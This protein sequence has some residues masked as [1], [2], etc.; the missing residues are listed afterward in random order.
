LPLAAEAQQLDDFTWERVLALRHRELLRFARTEAFD[1]MALDAGHALERGER[2]EERMTRLELRAPVRRDDEHAQLRDLARE[3]LEQPQRRL[4]GGVE[5]V[6]HEHE[7]IGLGGRSQPADDGVMERV[8]RVGVAARRARL[9]ERRHEVRDVAAMRADPR[10]ELG[11]PTAARHRFE[12][13]DP[14][15]MRRGGC[16]RAARG[17][18]Y[19]LRSAGARAERELV[20]GPRLADAR[21]AAEQHDAPDAA[22]RRLEG[23]EEAAQERLASDE[24]GRA[25]VRAGLVARHDLDRR[26]EAKAAAANRDD[27]AGLPAVVAEGPPQVAEGDAKAASLTQTPARLRPGPRPST[28]RDRAVAEAGA[29]ARSA[30]ARAQPAR[31]RAANSPVRGSSSNVPERPMP[32][33]NTTSPRAASIGLQTNTGLRCL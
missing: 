14:D 1:A 10:V 15:V 2:R 8:A 19:G 22:A 16:G 6:D 32:K 5:I 27:E 28:P 3:R 20:G 33:R 29:A 25:A 24:A 23:R 4:V 21:L 13:L 9:A 26:H 12:D 30:C 7:R 31:R 17:E 11:G 18:V